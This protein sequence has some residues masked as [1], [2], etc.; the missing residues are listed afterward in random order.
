MAQTA[1][2]PATLSL[3][4]A[5]NMPAGDVLGRLGT[6]PE[7][8]TQAEAAR[9]L[10]AYGPNAIRT[11]DVRALA[12]LGRQLKNPLLIL[13]G[14]ATLIA[15]AT[16]DHTDAIII[17]LIVGLSVGL[18]FFNEYRSERVVEA[19]HSSIRHQAVV[20]RDGQAAPVDVTSLVLGDVVQLRTGDLVP[21][22]MRLVEV[23]ELESD[24]AVLTGE[25]MPK[26]KSSDP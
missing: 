17:L 19:L 22:D 8:L 10:A 2:T 4:E 12:I 3:I 11:H 14:A 16:G 13:L 21:A 9:R 5:G 25:A 20:V 26:S 18:G 15:L 7:G 23:R 6:T 1:A 24:Q